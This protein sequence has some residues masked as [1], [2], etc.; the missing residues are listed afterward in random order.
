M[1][2]VVEIAIVENDDEEEDVALGATTNA[3][4]SENDKSDGD[5]NAKGNKTDLEPISS[6]SSS[7]WSDDDEEEE[8]TVPEAPE[9]A[10]GVDNKEEVGKKSANPLR[11][12]AVTDIFLIDILMYSSFVF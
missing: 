8:K 6:D 4:V 2:T 9:K 10:A 11:R 7:G 1:G 5:K 12:R 3:A